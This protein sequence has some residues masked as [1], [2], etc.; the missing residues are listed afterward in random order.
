MIVLGAVVTAGL[1][2]ATWLTARLSVPAV[3]GRAGPATVS[4]IIPARNEAAALP[5]LLDSVSRLD[6]A[7]HEVIVVDDESTDATAALAAAGGAAVIHCG[8]PPTGWLGKPWACRAGARAATG[9]HLLFLDADT[10]LAPPA[11]AALLDEHAG[12][13]GLL[14]VQP[15]HVTKQA[16]EGLSAYCSAVAVMGTGAFAWR[17]AAAPIAFG[18]CLMTC[19]EDYARVGGHGAVRA[20][21]LEDVHLARRYRDAGLPVS[22]FA[23]GPL[24]RSRPYPGGPRQMVDGWSRNLAAGAVSASPLAVAGTVV[25]VA[26]HVTVTLRLAVAL[27]RWLR[28][29]GPSPAAPL[30]A[31]V[32]VAAHQRWLLRR[33]GSFRRW[34]AVAFPVPLLAFLAMFCRSTALL[35]LRR[36]I[37]WRG[38]RV[39]VRRS[40]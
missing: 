30:L 3:A 31:F 27:H 8:A 7:P 6:P 23:G 19:A 28:R 5:A 17:P 40:T 22:C 29:R 18:P 32:A 14:S 36:D 2:A 20:E 34:T 15:H 25:W 1:A 37:D 33:I 13:G 4:I 9:T 21:I 39:A 12:R 26:S 38:R 16:Y 35:V 10:W 24:V 11:L